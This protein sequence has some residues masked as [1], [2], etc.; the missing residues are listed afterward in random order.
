MPRMHIDTQ[1]QTHLFKVIHTQQRHI[2]EFE[3]QKA[4]KLIKNIIKGQR[5]K[6]H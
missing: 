5:E 2:N 4:K 1:N 3:E 6:I